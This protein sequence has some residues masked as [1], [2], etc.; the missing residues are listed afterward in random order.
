MHLTIENPDG[1]FHLVF[2]SSSTTQRREVT[3]CEVQK[4]AATAYE[5]N[6]ESEISFKWFDLMLLTCLTCIILHSVHHESFA[7]ILDLCYKDS[8]YLPV[9]NL[10]ISLQPI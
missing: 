1:G 5:K 2:T 4:V 6:V 9:D 3:Y 10:E 8:A 7:C